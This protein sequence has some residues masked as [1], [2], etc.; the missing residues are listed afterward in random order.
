MTAVDPIGRSLEQYARVIASSG[1]NAAVASAEELNAN[2]IDP[3]QVPNTDELADISAAELTSYLNQLL[4]QSSEKIT[5][6]GQEYG[7]M[8]LAGV[9]YVLF[10]G[11]L[12]NAEQVQVIAEDCNIIDGM[13]LLVQVRDTVNG[14]L[15]E[16]DTLDPEDKIR[17]AMF[18]A[19]SSYVAR[20]RYP[21]G[22]I[23]KI[24]EEVMQKISLALPGLAADRLAQI[25][26]AL[27]AVMQ[28][29]NIRAVITRPRA[30][31]IPQADLVA[32]ANY[33]S[34]VSAY[35]K[36]NY[37]SLL[38]RVQGLVGLVNNLPTAPLDIRAKFFA[39]T[40]NPLDKIRGTL[41][42]AM[43]AMNEAEVSLQGALDPQALA[44]LA[45]SRGKMCAEGTDGAWTCAAVTAAD[46]PAFPSYIPNAVPLDQMFTESGLKWVQW[47]LWQLL[48]KKDDNDGALTGSLPQP[49]ADP[50]GY[51]GVGQLNWLDNLAVKYHLLPHA[52]L[53]AGGQYNSLDANQIGQPD[54]AM[55]SL[56]GSAGL[57]WST[58][59]GEGYTLSL[60]ADGGYRY[61]G[62]F[63]SN[64][65][66]N[67]QSGSVSGSVAGI[68]TNYLPNFELGLR[69]VFTDNER[70]ELS[71]WTSPTGNA[72]SLNA[73]ISQP[74]YRFGSGVL[75]LDVPGGLDLGW[76]EPFGAGSG[77][78]PDESP[79]FMRG[80][81]GGGLRLNLD[82][83]LTLFAGYRHIWEMPSRYF[84]DRA[85][86]YQT[87][88]GNGA[89]L[90]LG[91]QAGL[92]SG[93]LMFNYDVMTNWNDQWKLSYFNKFDL[94]G[95][96]PGFGVSAGQGNF[97]DVQSTDVN[98][99]A[100]VYDIKINPLS[101]DYFETSLD[102]V[103]NGGYSWLDNGSEGYVVGGGVRINFG[104][105]SDP[106]GVE[107]LYPAGAMLTTDANLTDAY[108]TAET[109]EVGAIYTDTR[110]QQMLGVAP[111]AITE[112]M[113]ADYAQ[114]FKVGNLINYQLTSGSLGDDWDCSV[115][116]AGD[117]I[118]FGDVAPVPANLEP[119][120]YVM[121]GAAR[122]Q[123]ATTQ[124]EAENPVKAP[125]LGTLLAQAA[126][127]V[128]GMIVDNNYWF[129]GEDDNRL[130]QDLTWFGASGVK[131]IKDYLPEG[132][133]REEF[134]AM[135]KDELAGGVIGKATLALL[136]KRLQLQ[137]EQVITR[138][139]IMKIYSEI[140][141][142]A[143]VVVAEE[144][145][146]EEAD[147]TIEFTIVE[148][149]PA[150][151]AQAEAG[152]TIIA[153]QK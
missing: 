24:V 54:S 89:Y 113:V 53:T 111:Y 114:M 107:E 119:R 130:P 134:V 149:A 153:P 70:S 87:Y 110:V 5:I 33:I 84:M 48:Q 18:T 104:P 13:K 49:L 143:P 121:I 79:N 93:N 58:G 105:S 68:S 65:E 99:E 92:W 118:A 137:P 90:G 146:T 1:G 117:A 147:T 88:E 77:P 94:G 106:T 95:F 41:E 97:Y 116:V 19:V 60:G 102:V 57:D 71:P 35:G 40:G 63:G 61:Q 62:P 112:Q 56:G 126:L 115:A 30:Q 145:P 151:E 42:F 78:L 138:E 36:D 27:E 67:F 44:I 127:H 31:R 74:L 22:R 76:Y 7:V 91:A 3:A 98:G 20:G 37:D 12:Q 85:Y 141:E 123:V 75:S 59:V 69:G 26:T 21:A 136:K 120:Q 6:A 129:M 131:G 142:N 152:G 47:R 64:S 15:N 38:Q 17:T 23:P 55:G 43:Q 101:T 82:V 11:A 50:L 148:E 8:T 96:A 34:E 51:P 103:A 25:R 80:T 4:A 14:L 139:Y 125:I 100:G 108:L 132:T 109:D 45:E 39:I 2:S 46:V 9:K 135:L 52:Q 124:S 128:T 81:I 133:T 73:L 86:G 140:Q 29:T 150:G 83:P 16:L 10:Q 28:E 66:P 144:E 122:Y 32:F 72:F